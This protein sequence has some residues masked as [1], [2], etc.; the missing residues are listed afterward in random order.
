MRKRMQIFGTALALG[1]LTVAVLFLS[2]GTSTAQTTFTPFAAT[3]CSADKITCNTPN[4]ITIPTAGR[5]VIEQVSGECVSDSADS[6]LAALQGPGGGAPKVRTELPAIPNAVVG[7][8]IPTTLT[9]IYP[10][11]GSQL[12]FFFTPHN[13]SQGTTG[14][15]CTV[16]IIGHTI[17]P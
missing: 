6:V 13:V 7:F 8:V 15:T 3:L 2:S 1:L 4:A 10:E 14:T 9:R 11:P 17:R 16:W 12:I 5:T